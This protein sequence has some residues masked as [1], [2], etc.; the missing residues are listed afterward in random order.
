MDAT[1]P[2]LA[3]SIYVGLD[4]GAATSVLGLVELTVDDVLEHDKQNA[5]DDWEEGDANVCL[6]V[7]F[8]EADVLAEQGVGL[9]QET[10]WAPQRIHAKM[11]KMVRSE[12]E[13]VERRG[14]DE[15]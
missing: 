4:T 5:D 1:L 2:P 6:P 15:L 3:G 12:A 14:G 9:R 7:P 8:L 11:G 10:R 13:K